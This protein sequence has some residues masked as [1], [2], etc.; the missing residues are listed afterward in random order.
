M[1]VRKALR[2]ITSSINEVPELFAVLQDNKPDEM[3]IIVED[4]SSQNRGV[5]VK[6]EVSPVA[7]GTLLSP[8][9]RDVVA[10]V[11]EEFGFAS[12]KVVSLPDLYGGKLCAALDRQHPRDL[13]D[14]KILLGLRGNRLVYI[15][16]NT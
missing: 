5:Q 15:L 4:R 16:L 7:R 10:L 8:I 14:I 12:M 13:F 6:I 11:E 2:A 3:R 9:E 1:N